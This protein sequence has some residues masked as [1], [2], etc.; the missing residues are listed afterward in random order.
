MSIS[1]NVTNEMNKHMR[2]WYLSHFLRNKDSIESAQRRFA[3]F[4]CSNTHSMDVDK[5]SDKNLDL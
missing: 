4:L 2:F 1:E 5:D 3:S